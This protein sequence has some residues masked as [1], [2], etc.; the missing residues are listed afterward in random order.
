MTQNILSHTLVTL[1]DPHDI[2]DTIWY[3]LVKFPWTHILN[4]YENF[5]PESVNIIMNKPLVQVLSL[6]QSGIPG[7]GEL[8]EGDPVTLP[9]LRTIP[10]SL[11]TLM[12]YFLS[13]ST[14]SSFKPINCIHSPHYIGVHNIR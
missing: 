10:P 13:S 9:F 12:S 7:G 1:P 8:L 3:L 6:A 4:Q 14:T 2:I 11:C 5:T